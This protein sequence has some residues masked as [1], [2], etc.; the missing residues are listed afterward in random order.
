MTV[1]ERKITRKG[2]WIG[3]IGLVSALMA[4]ILCVVL[5]QVFGQPEPQPMTL[6]ALELKESPPLPPPAA[7][8]YGENDF[9]YEG[10]YLTCTAG[11]SVLGIDVS[12]WQTVT[13]WNAVRDAGVEFVMIRVGYRGY[14]NGAV[15]ADESALSHYQGAKAAGLK[16]GV[17]F[18]S[19]A[20]S[21][22]EAV[23][24]ARFTMDLISDWTLDMPVVFDW[25]YVSDEARTAH[26][27][28]PELTHITM[29]FCDAVRLSGYTPM[30]YFNV[31]QSLYLLL[32]ERLT[33][34]QFWLAMY[35]DRMTYP[36]ALDMWQYSCSGTVPGI[37]G[38]V[39]MN[40][41]FPETGE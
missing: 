19:Q 6:P 25:E 9:Q 3:V 32:M 4:V 20:V 36:Y 1:Q 40:L 41:W 23:E 30:V 28:A 22:R 31:N 35:S 27:T 13:D 18:F 21:V 34:Y 39:D 11:E 33:D 37:E 15:C 10:D 26:L 8:P 14:G 24:E 5:F 16:V 29:A 17:Y 38:D 2:L 12:E 7:N